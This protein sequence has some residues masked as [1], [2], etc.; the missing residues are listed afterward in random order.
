VGDIA[1]D[2]DDAGFGNE[3][4][5]AGANEDVGVES[6]VGAIRQEGSDALAIFAAALDDDVAVGG[7]GEAAGL[8]DDVDESTGCGETDGPR[9]CD[10]AENCNCL[11]SVFVDEDGD[12]RMKEKSAVAVFFGDAGGGLGWSESLDREIADEGKSDLA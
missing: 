10:L 1:E 4:G 8:G 9:M 2:V 11:C 6:V 5:V 7:I 3:D 12:L